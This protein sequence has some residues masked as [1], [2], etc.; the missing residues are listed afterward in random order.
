MIT[1]PDL[2]SADM[3][4]NEMIMG[5]SDLNPLSKLEEFP[6]TEI[7]NLPVLYYMPEENSH[8]L[9]QAFLST[10]PEE[11]QA[12]CAHISNIEQ[13]QML[14]SLNKA[15]AFYPKGL[16]EYVLTDREHISYLHW[17]GCRR[18]AGTRLRLST[19][20]IVTSFH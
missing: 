6:L 19:I 5:V 7:G 11:C 9:R 14:V 17:R 12:S 13:M 18:G 10:L 1:E 15:V 16:F 20:G 2:A 4:E 3:Y 8:Y